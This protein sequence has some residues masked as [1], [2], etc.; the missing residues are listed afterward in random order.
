METTIEELK[1]EYEKVWTT[2]KGISEEMVDYC[3]NKIALYLKTKDGYFYIL[4]K[5][6]LNTEFYISEG[7]NRSIDEALNICKEI[8]TKED[9]FIEDNLRNINY[10]IDTIK[11]NKNNLFFA[12]MYKNSKIVA[13]TTTKYDALN[14]ENRKLPTDEEIEVLKICE[15]YKELQTKK[16]NSYLKRFGLSKIKANTFC[17]DR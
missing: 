16:I 7:S 13:I 1:K 9:F 12:A 6:K 15:K 11:N 10:L 4:E 5:E 8:K 3:I 17:G 2:E 14:K